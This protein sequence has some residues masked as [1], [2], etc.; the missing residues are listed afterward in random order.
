M[1]H[2]ID[3]NFN[4]VLKECNTKELSTRGFFSG[5]YYT[6]V[7]FKSGG[8][9]YWIVSSRYNV[10][11]PS[12]LPSNFHLFRKLRKILYKI[13]GVTLFVSISEF[14]LKRDK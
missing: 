10:S 11:D 12:R 6:P 1:A 7:R 13:T 5:I 9:E 14:F 2:E 3:N 8:N 4:S